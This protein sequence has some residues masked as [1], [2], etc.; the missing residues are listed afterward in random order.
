MT[1]R[2]VWDDFPALD[3]RLVE[4][5]AELADLTASER[6]AE[7]AR[8]MNEEYAHVV[9]SKFSPDKVRN[10]LKRIKFDQLG[11]RPVTVLM[12]NFDR[13][14]DIIDGTVQAPPKV[15]N[16]RTL[17]Q[18]QAWMRAGTHKTL[19]V[20]D[21]HIPLTDE[22]AL[23][24][25]VNR[26][27]TAS[28]VVLNGDTLDCYA[29]S[30][31]AKTEEIPI[32]QELDMACR[33]FEWL[34]DTF[35]DAFVVCTIGN[36]E[37]RVTR[38]IKPAIPSGLEFLVN[39]NVL[40]LL[41]RPFP[42]IVVLDDFFVQQADAIYA[43]AEATGDTGGGPAVRT[44]EWFAERRDELDLEPFRVV[45][46]AHT[47]KCSVTHRSAWRAIESGAMCLPQPYARTTKVRHPHQNGYVVVVQKDGK[48]DPYL[49]REFPVVPVGK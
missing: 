49:T 20:S 25:A 19:C 38:R 15:V 29:I 1:G 48:M 24:E 35:P 8:V 39:T 28:L 16:G 23:Q 5:S 32:H 22:A 21:L 44:A 10:R 41:A 6:E 17:A 37:D 11:D 43:H 7:T 27:L 40:H 14:R 42:N 46:Q 18:H 12:P 34:S 31:F 33:L 36:H 45:I 3:R 4:L 26:N 30:T 9:G 2:L 47:H 13:F